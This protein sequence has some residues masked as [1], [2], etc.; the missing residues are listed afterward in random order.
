MP[1]PS[2]PRAA[3]DPNYVQSAD[4]EL[5]DLAEAASVASGAST[6]SKVARSVILSVTEFETMNQVRSAA[7]KWLDS[8]Y[9]GPAQGQQTLAAGATTEGSQG[10][11][12]FDK[13]ELQENEQRLSRRN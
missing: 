5:T 12:D 9:E 11:F 1:A 2:I 4:V 6:P 8:A 3:I 10:I 13:L 7:A